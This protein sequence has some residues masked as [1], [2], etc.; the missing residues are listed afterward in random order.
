MVTDL[1]YCLIGLLALF[2]R[3]VAPAILVDIQEDHAVTLPERPAAEKPLP[4][5]PEQQTSCAPV[6]YETDE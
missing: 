2:G 1:L 4:A 5:V 6:A 3:R